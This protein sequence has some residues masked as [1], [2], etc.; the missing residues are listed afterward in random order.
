MARSGR[1]FFVSAAVGAFAP[2]LSARWP[3]R[4]AV[5]LCSRRYAA[6]LLLVCC[7][8]DNV[9]AA[10]RLPSGGKC[11][12]AVVESRVGCL[13][14]EGIAH[15]TQHRSCR[16]S[17]ITPQHLSRRQQHAARQRMPLPPRVRLEENA[18]AVV[19]RGSH[20]VAR[21]RAQ[22]LFAESAHD[23]GHWPRSVCVVEHTAVESLFPPRGRTPDFPSFSH[24]GGWLRDDATTRHLFSQWRGNICGAMHWEY[25]RRMQ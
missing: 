18:S 17:S 1:S 14:A 22:N 6:T 13:A 2:D 12:S 11:V 9:P 23:T 5:T 24:P 4:V 15:P 20:C 16:A 3:Q 8:G 21:W 19:F 7:F 25:E 10:V